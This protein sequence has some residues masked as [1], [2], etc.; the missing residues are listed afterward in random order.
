MTPLH[1][2]A[3]IK[4]IQVAEALIKAGAIVNAL[5]KVSYLTLKIWQSIRLKVLD[6][7]IWQSKLFDTQNECIKLCSYIEQSVILVL[8]ILEK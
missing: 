2:A 5:D 6:Q 8:Y 1:F 7:V 4:N 3:Q